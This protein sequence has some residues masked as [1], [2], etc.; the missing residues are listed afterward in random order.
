MNPFFTQFC[1]S[2][3]KL[4]IDEFL[5]RADNENH[6]ETLTTTANDVFEL[7]NNFGIDEDALWQTYT[8][9]LFHAGLDSIGYEV[10]CCFVNLLSGCAMRGG[11]AKSAKFFKEEWHEISWVYLY[12][13]K[14]RQNPPPPVTSFGLFRAGA[15]TETPINS[16]LNFSDISQDANLERY[17]C[18]FLWKKV[19]QFGG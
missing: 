10:N 4:T 13:E 2:S 12:I 6:I 9:Q 14:L 15:V 18:S 11:G 1:A 16:Y 7:C 19:S 3:L 8:C 17:F 5:A